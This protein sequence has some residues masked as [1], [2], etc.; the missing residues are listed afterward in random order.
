MWEHVP[1]GFVGGAVCLPFCKNVLDGFDGYDESERLRN[2]WT[3]WDNRTQHTSGRVVI[4]HVQGHTCADDVGLEPLMLLKSINGAP[5]N[6]ISDLECA[7]TKVA[8]CRPHVPVKLEFDD[9]SVNMLAGDIVADREL[10]SQPMT[11]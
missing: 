9:K 7:M 8:A 10:M 11:C 6:T 2:C 1:V 3:T 5:V 4:V